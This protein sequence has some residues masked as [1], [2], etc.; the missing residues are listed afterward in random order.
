M[1][2]VTLTALLLIT[3]C[4][5]ASGA[6]TGPADTPIRAA[7]FV[8]GPS[9]PN[10]KAVRLEDALHVLDIACDAGF[11]AV[12]VQLAN[13][14]ELE[15]VPLL[16]RTGAWTREQLEVF[17]NH[18]A[19]CGIAV[20]PEIKLLTHQEKFFQSHYPELMYNAVSY[21]PRHGKTYDIVLPML[22][23]I[24]ELMRPSAIHIGHDEVVGWNREH[25]KKKLRDGESMLPA[26][27]F[28]ADVLTL[29]SYLMEKGIE[30][31]MWGDMLFAPSEVPTMLADHLHG[32]D[33]GF[34][35]SLR[36]KLPRDIV[37]CDWHYFDQQ[38]AFPTMSILQSEGF[39]VIGATWRKG[40]T[41]ANFSAFAARH[42]AYG[43]MAT[44]WFYVPLRQWSM[45]ESILHESGR[46]FREADW[47]D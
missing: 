16:R 23:E 44:I 36:Q 22:D 30:I 40:A 13:S 17:M 15:S 5:I 7:H 45:V 43:M 18:A 3:L 29:H 33:A 6:A 1:G 8:L 25:A 14:I 21:D 34:G 4:G 37:I 11:N 41:T 24:I 2:R 28:L 31:W 19:A 46:L 47:R 26:D 42:D 38:S 39:R 32:G 10:A 12:V 27:L 9:D 20:I 35:Q